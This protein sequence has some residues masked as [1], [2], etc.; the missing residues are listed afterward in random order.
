M[1]I[2]RNILIILLLLNAVLL[3]Y[4]LII[5]KISEYDYINYAIKQEDIQNKN[6]NNS[7]KR[8]NF[9]LDNESIL[10][11]NYI[12]EIP[13]GNVN[14]KF[15]DLIEGG[16]EEIYRA[17]EGMNEDGLVNYLNR[18]SEDIAMKTGITTLA[19]FVKFVQKIQIYRDS[20]IK[21]EKAEIIEGSYVKGNKYDTF[22]VELSYDNGQVLVFNVSLSNRDFIDTPIIIIK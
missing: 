15:T 10:L 18:N 13:T 3:I 5:P 16:F 14:V 1:K 21:C 22:K 20:N 4:L 9:K 11:S 8:I 12:G 6:I 7:E 2:I 17:T 19:D